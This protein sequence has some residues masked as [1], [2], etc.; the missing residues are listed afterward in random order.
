M[1][2]YIIVLIGLVSL[3]C[4]S[5]HTQDEDDSEMGTPVVTDI[6]RQDRGDYQS[7]LYPR[8]AS[9]TTQDSESEE[10]LNLES[11][12]EEP[13]LESEEEELDSD[14]ENA[15]VRVPTFPLREE[16]RF[17]QL[18]N[19]F[20]EVRAEQEGMRA[21]VNTPDFN[22]IADDDSVMTR[23]PTPSL[24]EISQPDDALFENENMI[25]PVKT[26]NGGAA[27]HSQVYFEEEEEELMHED[28]DDDVIS[29][30]GMS[31]ATTN[32]SPLDEELESVV[33]ELE[34]NMQVATGDNI[35]AMIRLLDEV[36]N[37]INSGHRTQLSN[38]ARNVVLSHISGYTPE[39]QLAMVKFLKNIHSK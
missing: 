37:H 28:N 1:K 15:M 20:S 23:I 32:P 26:L 33:L 39:Q 29:R 27:Y 2:K 10:E 22:Y 7:G 34:E 16:E 38:H 14:E 9:F 12:E 30:Q 13:D 36:I 24:M 18:Q 11:E 4:A 35:T 6:H 21:P 25:V 19:T 5:V 17:S 8:N 3:S 31:R